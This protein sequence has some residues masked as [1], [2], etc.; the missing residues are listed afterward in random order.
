MADGG[1]SSR[2]RT[3][4]SFAAHGLNGSKRISDALS[5]IVMNCI[6]NSKGKF[7]LNEVKKA[8]KARNY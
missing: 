7:K 8:R 5:E 2:Q 1:N 4:D 6:A 3:I